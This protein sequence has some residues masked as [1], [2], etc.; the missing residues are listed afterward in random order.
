MTHELY[1]DD[2]LMDLKPDTNIAMTIKSNLFQDLKQLVSNSTYTIHLPKTV[3]NERVLMDVARIQNGGA[4]ARTRHTVRY[5]VDGVPV[6]T[7][8]LASLLSVGE[9]FEISISWGIY[10]KVATLSNNDATLKD[11]TSNA[12]ILFNYQNNPE[13]YATAMARGYFFASYDPFN[14]ERDDDWVYYGAQ[15]DSLGVN[16]ES[17]TFSNGQIM[18][19]NIGD[20]LTME[21]APTAGRRYAI[22]PFWLGCTTTLNNII[23]TTGSQSWCV[24]D[25]LNV[26]IDVGNDVTLMGY[27]APTRAAYII[28]NTDTANGTGTIFRMITSNP[29]AKMVNAG[30]ALL[31]NALNY[32]LPCVSVRWLLDQIN[33]D[34]GI[35]FAWTGAKKAFIDSLVVPCITQKTLTP[36]DNVYKFEAVFQNAVSLGLQTFEVTK[37]SPIFLETYLQDTTTLNV[38]TGMDC[39]CIFD[40]QLHYNCN[41]AGWVGTNEDLFAYAPCFLDI[42]VTRGS[43]VQIYSV[44][45]NDGSFSVINRH[46]LLSDR[47]FFTIAGTGKIDLQHADIITFRLKNWGFWEDDLQISGGVIRVRAD[48]GDDMWRGKYFPIVH[49]LPDIKVLDFIK[50][51]C[52]I[53]ATFPKQISATGVVDMKT[54][55]ALTDV[56]D[57][58]DWSEKI[59]VF[60]FPKEAQFTTSEWARIN[61]Y[62]YKS[63][64]KTIGNYDG[65]LVISNTTL[66]NERDVMEFPFA[67]SDGRTIP[68][69]SRPQRYGDK[70]T[71]TTT[72]GGNKLPSFAGCEPRIM[73][74]FEDAAH[75]IQLT[76]NGLDMQDIIDNTYTG[77][78]ASLN[79]MTVIKVDVNL[80][81]VDVMNI[82]ETKPIYIRQFASYFALLT[83]D[84]NFGGM[85]TAQLMRIDF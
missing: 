68:L 71:N 55:D 84:V 56:T 70:Q 22:V 76:F 41:T 36:N 85:S 45:V 4:W 48:L 12:S 26:V 9:D 78:N 13:D 34:Y 15:E 14:V 27:D 75:K 53:T 30:G 46:Q 31:Y 82:D 64:D 59:A 38:A 67:A 33:A 6:I 29:T 73:V 44:G 49:N 17:V 60:T 54:Q 61:R 11:L 40:V 69:W 23:G 57:A 8:G 66:E 5:Y 47:A 51:L 10:P 1:I 21:V 3:S 35:D 20:R 43:D 79:D 32:I 19:G 80:S 50:Y 37:A 81:V 18:T 62:K 65:Q 83:L 77:Y 24:V 42:E 63:D 7:D 52:V 72:D 25:E 2:V 74:G 58:V 28:I 39:T 16:G